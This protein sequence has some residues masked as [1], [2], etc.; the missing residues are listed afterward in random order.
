ML[1]DRDTPCQFLGKLAS[2]VFKSSACRR[3]RSK[4]LAQHPRG[5]SSPDRSVTE[6]SALI[7]PGPSS[8]SRWCEVQPAK[9]DV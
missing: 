8:V 3:Q 6:T 1:A 2:L 9:G 7:L 5:M 4:A